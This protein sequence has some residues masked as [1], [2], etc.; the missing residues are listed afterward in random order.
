MNV[1]S[2]KLNAESNGYDLTNSAR[3]NTPALE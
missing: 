3:F 1:N 2:G